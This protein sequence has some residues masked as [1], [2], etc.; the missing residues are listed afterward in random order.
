MRGRD[1]PEHGTLDAAAQAIVIQFA[2]RAFGIH[3]FIAS[4]RRCGR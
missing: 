2:P 1:K 4:I 3:N